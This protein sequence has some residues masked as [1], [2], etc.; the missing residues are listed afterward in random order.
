MNALASAG[1]AAAVCTGST[2]GAEGET[3]SLFR[4]VTNAERESIQSLNAF[5]NPPGIEV[6]YFSTTLEGAQSYASQ[7]TAA[8]GE[9]PFTIV[10]TSIPTSSITPE[11]MVIVDR[12]I[13][14]IVVPTELLPTLSPPVVLP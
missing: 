5:S 2:T 14:T 4:A 13:P 6:K 11:M 1:A 8:Y 3:T 9:G 12:G 7:A 10:N